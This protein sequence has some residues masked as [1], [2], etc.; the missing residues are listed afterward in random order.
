MFL[1]FPLFAEERTKQ[2]Y[3]SLKYSWIKTEF[4]LDISET[5][6]DILYFEICDLK[7]TAS[8]APFVLIYNYLLKT[9]DLQRQ[10]QYTQH[11]NLYIR[12]MASYLPMGLLLLISQISSIHWGNP[13]QY[14]CQAYVD[15]RAS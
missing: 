14:Y 10:T 2:N 9:G 1:F 12:Q 11:R 4:I 3:T 5:T 6:F 13:D 8:K 7:V 15:L